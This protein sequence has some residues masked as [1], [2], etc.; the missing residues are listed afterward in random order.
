MEGCPGDNPEELRQAML[1]T[2]TDAVNNEDYEFVYEVSDKQDFLRPFEI[3]EWMDVTRRSTED[4][5]ESRRWG[6]ALT[7]Y[8][9]KLAG[10][11]FP[12]DETE[13]LEGI[14][15]R[16][17]FDGI[18]GNKQVG[19]EPEG[20][21]PFDEA[22]DDWEEDVFVIQDLEQETIEVISQSPIFRQAEKSAKLGYLDQAIEILQGAEQSRKVLDHFVYDYAVGRA[23]LGYIEE[24]IGKISDYASS[25]TA[26]EQMRRVL[27]KHVYDYAK[28]Q[29]N[30]GYTGQALDIIR[31]HASSPARR[32][33][34]LHRIGLL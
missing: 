21:E 1:G 23:K 29:V 34:M 10:R 4:P 17:E 22:N 3:A 24:A 26:A 12:D 33:A 2:L 32:T 27:D 28:R 20:A 19:E 13:V 7:G 5:V 11:E 9:N 6:D 16:L 30:L 14:G 25:E 8:L 31:S 18:V 15:K